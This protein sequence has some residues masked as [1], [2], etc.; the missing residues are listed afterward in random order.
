MHLPLVVYCGLSEWLGSLDAADLYLEL[1]LQ[2][3]LLLNVLP[4]IC[5]IVSLH[6]CSF[7]DSLTLRLS[8]LEIL[9][10]ANCTR[11]LPDRIFSW[12]YRVE[13]DWIH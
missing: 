3:V 4:K 8:A 10:Q 12:F 13:T 7:S 1:V 9:A 2:Y 5:H 11:N 6:V